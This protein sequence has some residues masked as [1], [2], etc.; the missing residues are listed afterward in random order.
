MAN[1]VI[2]IP[3]MDLPAGPDVF[4]PVLTGV[5]HNGFTMRLD[6]TGAVKPVTLRMQYAADGVD[7]VTLST[8]GPTTVADFLNRDGTPMVPPVMEWSPNLGS[9]S[10]DDGVTRQPN[11]TTAISKVQI[12]VDSAE[13]WH[14]LGGSITVI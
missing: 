10:A 14:T 9:F 11:L 8:E 6:M 13:A 3:A 2:P 7:F 1:T 12:A 5:G 4:G